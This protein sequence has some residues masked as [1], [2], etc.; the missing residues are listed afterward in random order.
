MNNI[1]PNNQR[2]FLF[3]NLKA[4]LLILVIFGHAIE[5]VIYNS[6]GIVKYIYTA[7]YIFHMP[8]FIFISGYFSKKHNTKKLISLILTYALWQELIYPFLLSIVTHKSFFDVYRPIYHPQASYWYLLA[9]I[10]WRALIPYLNK[11]K[12]I[13]PLS[14]FISL[15]FG[16][17]KLNFDLRYFALGRLIVFFPFFLLGYKC[18][19]ETIQKWRK[20]KRKVL[21]TIIFITIISLFTLLIHSLKKYGVNP[22]RPNRILMPHYYYYQCYKSITLSFVMKVLLFVV[23]LLSIPLMFKIVSSKP[24]FL[25]NIGRYSLPIYLLHMIVVHG[26]RVNFLKGLTFTDANLFTIAYFLI[27][28]TYCF[29]LS[30]KPIVEK[31]DKFINI[32]I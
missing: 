6:N 20:D 28:F 25:S 18:S 24:S 12:C 22:E 13:V 5:F 4:I 7:L 2:D 14:I 11:I 17:Y 3:D 21:N 16:F 31:L 23:Q 27:A 10:I 30:R 32:K 9:L 29:I 1:K 8:V 15:T 19:Q 26:I